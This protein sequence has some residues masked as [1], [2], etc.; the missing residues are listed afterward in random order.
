MCPDRSSERRDTDRRLGDERAKTDERLHERERL[1]AERSSALLKASRDKADAAVA[2]SRAQEDRRHEPATTPAARAE[3]DR[4]RHDQDADIARRR[5]DEDA[6]LDDERSE[7]R[8]LVAALLA[9]HRA[10]TDEA[11]R[12]ER[13]FA[14]ATTESH[15]SLLA[16]VSH[17]VRG[18]VAAITLSS[19]A[20]A[21]LLTDVPQSNE[22][23]HGIARIQRAAEQINALVSDLIDVAAIAAGQ[24]LVKPAVRE[25]A[26]VVCDALDAVQPFAAERAIQLRG[27][28]LDRP[29]PAWIDER[30]ILQVLANLLGNAI[31]FSDRGSEIR[32]ELQ[33]SG[34]TVEC[35]VTDSGIGIE[36][37]SLDTIFERFR[38]A[39]R[40]DIAGAG[41]GL[42]IAKAIIEAHGG[43][44]WAESRVGVGSTFHFAVPAAG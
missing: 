35:S 19:H 10:R 18:L 2:D 44:I 4:E 26:S 17:D 8:K 25:L 24:L 13:T 30:R 38:R 41:L 36:V 20:V 40:R 37:D 11:L 22:M 5:K 39:A 23:Q 15:D 32:V 42:Y 6:F 34:D 14:D 9:E 28:D 16:I 33:R 27:P 12:V 29:L 21:T 1:L 31:K 7:R 3:L 43:R